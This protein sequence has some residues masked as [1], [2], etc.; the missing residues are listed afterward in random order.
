[1]TVIRPVFA[2]NALV[3]SLIPLGIAIICSLLERLPLQDSGL[4]NQ[5]KE[6]SLQ[7]Y[8]NFF[9]F[10]SA[11][12]IVNLL[13]QVTKPAFSHQKSDDLNSKEEERT[14]SFNVNKIGFAISEAAVYYSMSYFFCQI[15]YVNFTY[16]S[17]S[18]TFQTSPL[19]LDKYHHHPR[20]IDPQLSES[21]EPSSPS[22]MLVG[23]ITPSIAE[24]LSAINTPAREVILSANK[25]IAFLSISEGPVQI[26]DISD[27]TQPVILN[28]V[29]A[30]P[31]LFRALVLSKDGNFLFA[32]CLE[33]FE[34]IDITNYRS[35]MIVAS[36]AFPRDI[37]ED[38]YAKTT[39]DISADGKTI[40]LASEGIAILDVS[41]L[42]SPKLISLSSVSDRLVLRLSPYKH[43]LFVAGKT[44]EAY[45][46]S[47]PHSLN[48]ISS[49]TLSDKALSLTI[50]DAKNQAYIYGYS[51]S[52][53]LNIFDISD[54]STPKSLSQV[55]MASDCYGDAEFTVSADG[56]NLLVSGCAFLQVLS[57]SD[58]SKTRVLPEMIY[59]PSSVTIIPG[60]TLALVSIPGEVLIL[61]Q[62][63][64]ITNDKIFN[65]NDQMIASLPM[66]MPP[67]DVVLSPDNKIAYL[68]TSDFGYGSLQFVDISDQAAPKLRNKIELEEKVNYQSISSDNKRAALGTDQ[69]LTFYDISNLDSTKKLGTLKVKSYENYLVS[70]D[71]KTLFGVISKIGKYLTLEISDITTPKSPKVLGKLSLELS[72]SRYE[73]LLSQD[74]TKLYFAGTF[75]IIIDVSDLNAP[76]ILG[77]SFLLN[78]VRPSLII[79]NHG[80]TAFLRTK[81]NEIE[82]LQI[83]DVSN[84]TNPSQISNLIF[85][86]HDEDSAAMTISKNNKTLYALIDNGILVI[87]VSLLISPSIVRVIKTSKP[88]S[89][90]I[91]KDDSTLFVASNSDEVVNQKY[92]G[93]RIWR[94]VP[95]YSLYL[96]QQAFSLG[97]PTRNKATVL[98]LNSHNK[99]SFID[100]DYKFNKMSLYSIAVMSVTNDPT[101]TLAALPNWMSFD[102]AN[103][104]LLIEPKAQFH[105]GSHV[106]HAIISTRVSVNAFL[107]V[108]NI[109]SETDSLRLTVALVSLGYLDNEGF[110]TDSFDSNKPLLLPPEYTSFEKRIRQ[111][112]S[113]SYIE[114][115][116]V[117]Q[118]DPS[119]YMKMSDYL[120]I[121]TESQE[122]INV[123]IKLT[124]LEK[125]SSQAR[126]VDRTFPGVT[127]TIFMDKTAMSLD[128]PLSNMNTALKQI[129]LNLDHQE[130]C[131]GFITISDGMNPL[132]SR[133]L[134]NISGFFVKNQDPQVNSKFRLQDQVNRY[135][136][137][138][139][140]PFTIDFDKKSF[141]ELNQEPLHYSLARLD[142]DKKVPAW[143]ALND[144]TLSGTPP[145]A[146]GLKYEFAI[147]AKNE[148]RSTQDSF[149][150]MVHLSLSYVARL[151]VSYGSY[152]ITIF[153]LW[154][155]ANKIY[156]I[157]GKKYYQYPKILNIPVGREITPKTIPPLSFTLHEQREAQ[158]LMKYL[159]PGRSFIDP[160]TERVDRQKLE[161]TLE[162]I[163]NQLNLEERERL[164]LYAPG[165]SSNRETIN[166]IIANIMIFRQLDMKSE[167]PTRKVFDQLLKN[168]INLV[169]RDQSSPSLFDI[170][171]FQFEQE[172]RALDLL[173]NDNYSSIDDKDVSLLASPNSTTKE[174]PPSDRSKNNSIEKILIPK[175]ELKVQINIGLLQDAL[176][177]HAFN[178]H[179]IEANVIRTQILSKQAST[180]PSSLLKVK[181]FL[182]LDLLD[183]AVNPVIGTGKLGYG[184]RYEIRKGTMYFYG[185]PIEDLKGKTLVI[186]ITNL[187][188]KILKEVRIKGVELHAEEM[189]LKN[190]FHHEL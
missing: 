12:I 139:G 176:C 137:L 124:N 103:G 6:T 9:T 132:L 50:S 40:Y 86:R 59:N 39:M 77:K 144:L 17:T 129:V 44:L 112:L 27:I 118:V 56:G 4:L 121:K 178:F 98:K 70:D 167:E 48:P 177:A 170:K 179:T 163:F 47:N 58:F 63:F 54:P 16:L 5:I 89:V 88:A 76:K 120:A 183:F 115:A 68:F 26:V 36:L 81:Y 148:F 111:I 34:V 181:Q 41:N 65:P 158:L 152:M 171:P 19:S 119:L 134:V 55:K 125:T 155:S 99:Y 97:K 180:R 95:Q 157:F 166:L 165:V 159:E 82:Y 128:G 101:V 160:Q 106:L 126:F 113:Q 25:K 66:D 43:I 8:A 20:I 75:L 182:N 188:N 2:K 135:N 130:Y 172:L 105:L 30:Y 104:V 7:A 185:T 93:L 107:N 150:L 174:S 94:Q 28:S 136:V 53:I 31:S 52:S 133:N 173:N 29:D 69:T 84:P 161:E 11:M 123:Q 90:A 143:L 87:D 156:N 127:K 64:D 92:L 164:S 42:T 168:W 83:L 147:I 78:E 187:K 102:K 45:D 114:M 74:N 57:L 162:N 72:N 122:T 62:Y 32:G 109:T 21:P 138:T 189:T 23:S 1:M 85:P 116:T 3:K 35:P 73:I 140:T 61:R 154:V 141:V 18:S 79:S 15:L 145:E 117:I 10:I 37:P 33:K 14:N 96:P 190:S 184:I 38:E 80:K 22:R 13:T 149:I 100:Q 142:G 60:T 24:V 91:S 46:V 186:Q 153:G 175:S 146:I 71:Q 67:S 131:N 169:E 51:S 108:G 49:T 151:C 110:L